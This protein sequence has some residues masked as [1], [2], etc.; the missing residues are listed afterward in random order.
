MIEYLPVASILL[1][2]PFVCWS[3][4]KTRTFPFPVMLLLLVNVIPL[5]HY[6]GESP[7][8]NYYLLALS[9]GL[10]VIALLLAVINAIGGADFLFISAILIFVQYNPFRFPRVFFPLDFFYTM[11][12]TAAYLPVVVFL[13]NKWKGNEY[14]VVQM[15]TKFPDGFPFMFP[16]S[17]AFVVTLVLEIV[18]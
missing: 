8:R 10:C 11:L 3:D 7:E 4:W 15:L 17:F 13:Y 16:I 14:P 18:I 5:L 1:Y 12:V 9:L 2:I 6:L